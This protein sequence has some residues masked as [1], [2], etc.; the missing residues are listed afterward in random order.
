MEGGVTVILTLFIVVGGIAGAVALFGA[1][2][3]VQ[4]RKEKGELG[5]VDGGRPEH[6]AVEDDS[7]DALA[8]QRT[9]KDTQGPE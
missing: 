1:G 7:D 3:Y 8:P 6:T 4:R 5:G 2:G 9:T